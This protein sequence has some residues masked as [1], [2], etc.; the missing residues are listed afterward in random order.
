MSAL[1]APLYS[2][3]ASAALTAW[4]GRSF[5]LAWRSQHWPFTVGRVTRS[6]AEI[7]YVPATD[8]ESSPVV[9]WFPDFVYH[10]RVGNREYVGRRLRFT[11]ITLRHAQ[12]SA[13]R[14]QPEHGVRVTYNP[15][16]PETLSWKRDR[17]LPDSLRS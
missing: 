10:Y 11:P 12:R 3:C 7:E 4:T 6:G 16:N 2:L 14:F 5:F 17:R 15:K 8:A 9:G 13:A 1:F